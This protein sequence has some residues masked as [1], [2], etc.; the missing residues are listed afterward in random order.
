M[1]ISSLSPLRG[2]AQSGTNRNK[3]PRAHNRE[4]V[5]KEAKTQCRYHVNRLAGQVRGIG[6]MIDENEDNIL[7]VRQIMAS[8][9]SLEKLAGRILKEESKVCNRDR[10]DKLVDVLF[11]LR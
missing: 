9:A 1:S 10:T 4:L 5:S 3:L 11:K 6:K 7:V 2:V 8:I